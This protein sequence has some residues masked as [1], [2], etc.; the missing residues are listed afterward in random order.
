MAT[1]IVEWDDFTGGFYVGAS[2]T[3]Q[4]R[5][6]FTGDNVAVA[7][8]DATLIPMYEP[9]QLTLTGTDTTSGLINNTALTEVGKPACLDRLMVFTAKTA[10]AAYLYAVNTETSVVTRFSLTLAGS[11]ADF[12]VSTPVMINKLGST[13]IDIYVPGDLNRIILVGIGSGGVFGGQVAVD[14]SALMTATGQTRLTNLVIWGARMVGWTT[15]AYLFFS[16]AA[17]FSSTWAATNYIIVGYA[18]DSISTITARNYDLIVGKPS[19]WFSVTGVL[20]YSA[21]VRQINNGLGV[22]PTDPVAEWNNSVVFNADTGTVNYPVNLYTVNGA[23]VTPMMFQRFSTLTQELNMSKGPLGTLQVCL[24]NQD[25]S[26]VLS[27][28]M[29]LLNQQNRWTRTQIPNVTA[30]TPATGTLSYYPGLAYVSRSTVAIQRPILVMQVSKTTAGV[31]KVGV[32]TVKLPT[33]EPGQTAS[34]APSTAV[35]LL[36]DFSSQIPITVKDVFVEVEVV[37]LETASAY[38]AASS[39]AVRTNMKYPIGDLAISVGDVSSTN[40]TT[41]ITNSDIPGTGTRF[42]GRV[43]RFRPDNPGYGYGIEIQITFSGVKVRRVMAVIE[44]QR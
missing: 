44:E 27:G 42:M 6:T 20:S 7:M 28:R 19:G 36:S 30:I 16:G 9:T 3:K 11:V 37:E 43:Y 34:R 32:H 2:A 22:I 21:A 41:S 17:A 10:S 38:T 15:S 8:D 29:W 40:M 12:V 39:V 26:T 13:N 33:F 1:R 31:H 24:T 35:A 14:I 5:N 23:R 25:S 18:E 4:P